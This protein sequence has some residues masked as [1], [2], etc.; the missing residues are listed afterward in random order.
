MNKLEQ[1]QNGTQ[2]E[3]LQFYIENLRVLIGVIEAT[4]ESN[5]DLATYD[6]RDHRCGTIH[7][8]AGWM[9]VTPHF[10]ALGVV[11][12]EG[13]GAPVRD[14]WAKGDRQAG[15]SVSDEIVRVSDLLF[16]QLGPGGMFDGSFS[17]LFSTRKMGLW[18]SEILSTDTDCESDKDL[19][20]ARLRKALTI[21]EAEL[22]ELEEAEIETEFTVSWSVQVSATSRENAAL[23]AVD[24]LRDPS[25][26][27]TIFIVES[28][29]VVEGCTRTVIDTE[30]GIAKVLKEL[31]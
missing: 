18:D 7:C 21:R 12:S 13:W 6:A 27:A 17:H 25:N 8:T 24:M 9:A 10:N 1:I 23:I 30:G 26:T 29:P 11:P 19:A 3:R 5:V 20:L 16:G 15:H 14:A 22:Q 4:P 2:Q 28:H 31:P